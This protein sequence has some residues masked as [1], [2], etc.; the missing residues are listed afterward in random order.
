ME[1]GN[2]MTMKT[3]T[4]NDVLT[5]TTGIFLSDDVGDLYDILNHLTESSLYTHQLG[6]AAEYA[7]PYIFSLYPD[8]E[9]IQVPEINSKE[10]V[11]RFILSLT[12][13][14]YRESYE[15]GQMPNFIPKDPLQELVEMFNDQKVDEVIN[16][17]TKEQ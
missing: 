12:L 16:S 3:F 9:D 11:D 1:I 10:E 2:G 4:L 17:K 14:G 7:R 13:S 15:L 6:R 5:V 8:L